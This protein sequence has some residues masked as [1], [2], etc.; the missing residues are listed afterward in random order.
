MWLVL[1]ERWDSVC[2]KTDDALAILRSD[3]DL[4][5]DHFAE[6]LPSILLAEEALVLS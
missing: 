5:D 6:D 3:P 1:L 4:L 2:A